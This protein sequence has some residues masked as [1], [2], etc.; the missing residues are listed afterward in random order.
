M[1]LKKISKNEIA[2]I[3]TKVEEAKKII[4]CL[5]F[6]IEGSYF[7]EDF[8]SGKWDGKKTFYKKNIFKIGLLS[9]VESCL[10]ENNIEYKL[11]DFDKFLNQRVIHEGELTENLR[12]EQKQGV[13]Q[14]FKNP[15]GFVIIPTRG[16]KTFLSAECIRL[17]M[18]FGYK[19]SVFFVDTVDLLEQ[20]IQEF[21]KFFSIPEK[22][23]GK[24]QGE[25]VFVFKEINVA[26]IQSFTNVLFPP[27][28][29]KQKDKM[30]TY[31]RRSL[32]LKQIKEVS[33]LIIDEVQEYSSKKRTSV[34][35]YFE[36]EFKLALSAT[37][38]K[39]EQEISNFCLREA[40]GAELFEVSEKQLRESGSLVESKVLI[41]L[42]EPKINFSDLEYRNVYEE[43]VVSGERRMMMIGWVAKI[44]E[45][46]KI[47]TLILVSRKKQGY[48]LSQITEIPFVSGDDKQEIRKETK[49]NFL[50][51]EGG[52]LIA[53]N[54]YN[55]GVSLNNC[56]I[57]LNIGG[58]LEQS[59][60]IQKR[61]R[62]MASVDGKDTALIIDVFDKVKHLSKHSLS[63]LE[64]YEEK[65]KSENIFILN[66]DEDSFFEKF[67]KIINETFKK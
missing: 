2:F 8:K 23:I 65:T 64:V 56:E 43:L 46:K 25:D 52:V 33:F 37:P 4:E 39:S 61:G 5:T 26:M 58:G 24:L 57:L 44:L 10:K 62:V 29:R 16:G 3:P 12:E 67:E 41:I 47:K 27:K 54:I 19:K 34:I 7:S 20:T 32:L 42:F 11:I 35:N 30:Q 63:R 21:S 18:K 48:N 28:T 15:W 49:E 53:S 59:S 13:I 6:F 9:H 55:K 17:A 31:K 22:E 14:F 1:I 66:F 36:P 38:F 51:K 50:E 40:I 45:E 60:I